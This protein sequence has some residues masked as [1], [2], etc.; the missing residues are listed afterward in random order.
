[1]T[2]Q[3]F[4]R[5]RPR[6]GL[7]LALF[8]ILVIG[9]FILYPTPFDPKACRFQEDQGF[10]GIFA[11]NSALLQATSVDVPFG[12]GPED[13][14][15]ADDG[16]R[17]TG[18][19]NGDIVA[20]G[21]GGSN[22]VVANTGG[23]PLG[24]AFD[25]ADDL[26]IADSVKGLLRLNTQDGRL[27]T[28]S[29]SSENVLYGFTDDVDVGPDGSIYFSDA[30]YAY[31]LEDLSLEFMSCEPHGRL[32]RYDPV[33]GVSETLLGDL[34]FANGVAV[35]MEG[36]F[37]LV[38]ETP[39]YRVQRYWLTG[40]KAGTSDI[41][42]DNLP[43]FPDGISSDGAGGYWLALYAPRDPSLDHLQGSVWLKKL[44]S[45]MPD[46]LTSS[47]AKHGLVV[48]L[49]R[50][51]EIDRVFQDPD[52]ALVHG[53]TSIEQKG[54]TLYIGNLERGVFHTLSVGD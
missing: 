37:V 9:A 45:K 4:Y 31:G 26:I 10:T 21:A 51:L 36:D 29:R 48:H 46:W 28:L 44:L 47:T 5:S 12:V 17:Y 33:S 11:P 52:G 39:Q 50:S 49:N 22:R 19:A 54:D 7:R 20:F 38:N 18:L 24:L 13:I 15:I 27:A 23:R 34:Y 42:L 53:V 30:S 14:A 1:M 25:A 40:D 35:S 32:L 16:T 3:I 6:W 2:K 43:G 8:L 41:V